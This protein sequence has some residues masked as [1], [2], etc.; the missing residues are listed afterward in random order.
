MR[1]INIISGK[2]GTGKTLLCASLAELLGNQNVRV[3]VVDMDFFVRGLTSLLYYHRGESLQ[4]IEKSELSSLD[5]FNREYSSKS[6]GVSDLGI[7]Q[8][9]SFRVLPSVSRIDEKVK[10]DGL[11]AKDRSSLKQ[12]LKRLI[13]KVP[14]EFDYVFF[15]S[16]AG[17]DELIS[18]TCDLSDLSICVQEEDN[19]SDITAENLI[20]QLEDIEAPIFRMVNKLRNVSNY[21]QLEEKDKDG[22]S[23]IGSVPFD[24]DVL[25]SYGEQTFWEEISRSLY[26]QAVSRSW[27]ILDT[28]M[29]LGQKLHFKRYSPIGS[30]F[31]E[32]KL[33]GISAINRVLVIMGFMM[34]AIAFTYSI[35]GEY[36]IRK[37]IDSDPE[38]AISILIGIFGLLIAIFGFLDRRK[39]GYVSD[40]KRKTSNSR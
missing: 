10:L 14:K 20:K 34:S 19:I 26:K 2:G 23:F 13:D 30:D 17:Y 29:R 9:R 8:Y 25:N 27:N 32:S 3:L 36:G 1:F 38:R 15:D 31:I 39:K 12:D 37:L 40:S 11:V 6:T 22:V 7:Y 18:A 33:S 5:L 4:I 21:E 16:R 35:L 24:M 28:K